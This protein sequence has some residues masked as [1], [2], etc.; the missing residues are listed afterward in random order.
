MPPKE[1]KEKIKSNSERI[2]VGILLSIANGQ[3]SIR[4][5]KEYLSTKY[6]GSGKKT[7]KSSWTTQSIS[8]HLKD[9]EK[10]GWLVR[11]RMRVR[12]DYKFGSPNEDV[13]KK[14]ARADFWELRPNSYTIEAL[15]TSASIFMFVWMH[16]RDSIKE[17]MQSRWYIDSMNYA[18]TIWSSME[19]NH[20]FNRWLFENNFSKDIRNTRWEESGGS[21]KG[22]NLRSLLLRKPIKD[23][24]LHTNQANANSSQDVIGDRP[25]FR[26]LKVLEYGLNPHRKNFL[27]S[28]E[29]DRNLRKIG[30]IFPFLLGL[31]F[32]DYWERYRWLLNKL[33]NE[34]PLSAHIMFTIFTDEVFKKIMRKT[35][36]KDYMDKVGNN[37]RGDELDKIR[38]GTLDPSSYLPQ[39]LY[40]YIEQKNLLKG[41]PDY[42]H[43]FKYIPAIL[44][45]VL[46]GGSE[47]PQRSTDGDALYATPIEYIFYDMKPELKKLEAELRNILSRNEI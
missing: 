34:V 12:V 18:Y 4:E 19:G 1:N 45:Y 47:Y 39:T 35:I 5:I 24:S 30:T 29:Y 15:E 21:T 20:L 33:V 3:R 42:F 40:D 14:W 22:L 41:I 44:I 7:E 11:K 8:G 43:N 25:E 38:E 23:L 36:H 28:S 6:I 26:L 2:Q 46:M 31:Y 16:G 32:S 37:Y 17:L 13:R 10:K 9:M 27:F